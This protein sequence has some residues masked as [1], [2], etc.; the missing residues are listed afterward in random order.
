MTQANIKA[1]LVCVSLAL[2]VAPPYPRIIRDSAPGVAVNL[3]H[4]RGRMVPMYQQVD[5]WGRHLLGGVDAPLYSRGPNGLDDAGT[6]DDIVIPVRT[7]LGAAG[8]DAHALAWA[9]EILFLVVVTGLSLIVRA[10]PGL[11]GVLFSGLA[12][13]CC[14]G[15][16]ATMLVL[17]FSKHYSIE[18]AIP[19]NVRLAPPILPMLLAAWFFALGL[20]IVCS[21]IKGEL[22]GACCPPEPGLGCSS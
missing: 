15:T 21:F 14:L 9:R 2:M 20:S 3:W 4:L 18:L 13:S 12:R 7:R 6:G 5:P 1:F 11:K 10:A 19:A 8:W 16:S 22:K 17:W